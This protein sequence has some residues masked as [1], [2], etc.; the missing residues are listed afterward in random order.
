[1]E[2]EEVSFTGPCIPLDYSKEKVAEL[3]TCLIFSDAQA[4]RLLAN[5]QIKFHVSIESVGLSPFK[6]EFG[7]PVYVVK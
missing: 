7:D 2:K 5:G 1:M 3:G 4:E 6:F